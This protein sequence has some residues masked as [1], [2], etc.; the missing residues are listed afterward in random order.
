MEYISTALVDFLLFLDDP[1]TAVIANKTRRGV[2]DNLTTNLQTAVTT[3]ELIAMYLKPYS[4]PSP[5]PTPTTS[6]EIEMPHLRV[7][8]TKIREGTMRRWEKPEGIHPSGVRHLHNGRCLRE[9]DAFKH[10]KG[11]IYEVNG[12]CA[13]ER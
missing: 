7:A 2:Y 3:D 11:E 13:T 5:L 8:R 9:Q 4:P 6:H 1:A 10:P 12:I